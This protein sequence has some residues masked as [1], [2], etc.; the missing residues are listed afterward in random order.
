MIAARIA[1]D[2]PHRPPPVPRGWRWPGRDEIGTYSCYFLVIGLLFVVGYGGANWLAAQRAEPLRLYLQAELTV[3]F[4][5]AML[6]PYLSINLLFVLPLFRLQ[7]DELRRLGRQMIVTTVIA[8]ALFVLM[9]TAL[10][11]PR[12]ATDGDLGAAYQLLYALDLPYNCVPS[13]HVAYASQVVCALAGPASRALRM[14]LALWLALVV[15]STILTHQHHLLDVVSGLLLTAAVRAALGRR[16]FR[17]PV[18][19][20]HSVAAAAAGSDS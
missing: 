8:T 9:P 3:P 4:I 17:L 19:G 11:F 20:R 13:L 10:G 14:A 16:G 5:A 2:R 6:W 12:P 7:R 1:S 15:A 18:L